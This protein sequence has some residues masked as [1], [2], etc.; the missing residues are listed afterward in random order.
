[1]PGANKVLGCPRKYFLF[2]PQNFWQPLFSR[3]PNF[4]VIYPNF[5]F[6]RISCQIWRKFAPWMPPPSAASCPSKDIFLFF[7]CHLPTF[8]LWKLAPWMPPGRMPGAVAP[9]APPSACHCLQMFSNLWE[10]KFLTSPV[11]IVIFSLWHWAV[12]RLG[13]SIPFWGLPWRMSAKMREMVCS[14]A[15]NCRWGGLNGLAEVCKLLYSCPPASVSIR[16]NRPSPH[17]CSIGVLDGG[18]GSKCPKLSG[19]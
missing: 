15:D 7:F 8:F 4:F 12:F 11:I 13:E 6:F 14:N 16:T 5:I 10:S 1:M 19:I 2:V 9:S 17:L 18:L 3:S